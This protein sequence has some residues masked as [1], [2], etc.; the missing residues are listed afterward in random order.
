MLEPLAASVLS[1][2]FSSGRPFTGQLSSASQPALRMVTRQI[3]PQD[4]FTPSPRRSK[5]KERALPDDRRGEYAHDGASGLAGGSSGGRPTASLNRSRIDATRNMASCRQRIRRTANHRFHGDP[6]GMRAAPTSHVWIH[7][8]N[9]AQ[10]RHVSS[11]TAPQDTPDPPDSS[12]IP[13]EKDPAHTIRQMLHHRFLALDVAWETYE[14]YKLLSNGQELQP[15][16]LLTL[17]ERMLDSLQEIIYQDDHWKPWPLRISTLLYDIQP[18]VDDARH[19]LHS[20]WLCAVARSEAFAGNFDDAIK[21]SRQ[22]TDGPRNSMLKLFTI[23]VY[24]A[25]VIAMEEFLHPAAIV[26]FVVEEWDRVYP[27]LRNRPMPA[28]GAALQHLN[29]LRRQA[30]K[31]ASCVERPHALLRQWEDR[32]AEQRS[33]AA[34]FLVE[35]LCQRQGAQDALLVLEE[36][37]R[38]EIEVPRSLNLVVVKGLTKMDRL[39]LASDLLLSLYDDK[40]EP[41]LDQEFQLTGLYH[42]AHRGDLDRTKEYFDRLEAHGWLSSDAIALLLHCYSTLKD[43]T[44]AEV[45][46]KYFPSDGTGLFYP[47]IVHYTAVIRAFARRNDQKRMNEWLQRMLQAGIKPD[48]HVYTIVI[49]CFAEQGEV[50]AVA[51][52]IAQMRKAG[53]AP[54]RYAYTTVLSF[55]ADKRDSQA[56]EK[57]FQRALK[58]GVE[59]DRPMISALMDAHV[60]A[61]NWA[62][63]IQAF[64]YLR[65]SASKGLR[66]TV[67]VYNN[68]L[69]ACVLIGAPFRVISR[70]FQRLADVNVKPDVRTY[71]LLI[72]SA[73][74][75]GRMGTATSLFIEMEQH[76]KENPFSELGANVYILTLIMAGHLRLRDRR[77]AREVY[78]TMLKRGIDPTSV[79]YSIML[80]AYGNERTTQSIQLAE[81]FMSSLMEQG[82]HPDWMYV[83]GGRSAALQHVYGPVITAWSRTGNIERAERVIER[84]VAAGGRP[85]LGTL[86]VLLDVYRRKGLIDAARE[87]WPQIHDL[88]VEV[89]EELDTLLADDEKPDVNRKNILA[90][91]LSI[92][93]DALSAAGHHIEIANLWRQLQE[94]GFVF[95]SHNWN[96]LCVAL[97]RAGQ[98]LHAFE[99]LERIIL[100]N[101]RRT[102]TAYDRIREPTSPLTAD[103][104][105]LPDI[106]PHEPPLHR[107]R[108]RADVVSEDFPHPLQVLHQVS[109]AWNI[110]RPHNITLELLGQALDHLH[111]GH[112]LQPVAPQ[113]QGLNVVTQAMSHEEYRSRTALASETLEKIYELAPTAIQVVRQFQTWQESRKGSLTADG[114]VKKQLGFGSR[115]RK[116]RR[117]K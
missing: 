93:I 113:T 48:Q 110:W 27:F 28:S 107:P 69:K 53:L 25:I 5:G 61:G 98:P 33:R 77:R 17:A 44:A 37:R 59:P 18:L 73:C 82:D 9:G 46:S 74:D 57:I 43:A 36:L 4:F 72:Q 22:V 41:P 39:E 23:S 47:N 55:L 29:S 101:R 2:I 75:A 15:L 96:H 86:T 114:R 20:R 99:V 42:F 76:K 89:S 24:E 40:G 79:T 100:P 66:L 87:L 105:P 51:G 88:A 8:H 6:S 78:R 10:R 50:D 32:P 52:V 65:I 30:F 49:K 91:P 13:P 111:A 31:L 116:F 85:S 11:A 92:Y 115:R 106:A 56:A 68:L 97:L 81:D 38:Q 70:L 71:A 109:P 26:D 12:S 108:R 83:K 14:K 64:D 117:S 19:P 103:A 104:P 95:D 63:V 21:L 54:S 67:E 90:V 84:M 35:S 94:E 45:F 7:R 58:E 80:Q 3:L 60:E 34:Q 16:V 1:S 102:Y 62:G 112:I